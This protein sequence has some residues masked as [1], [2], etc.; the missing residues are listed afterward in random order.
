MRKVFGLMLLLCIGNLCIAQNK[1]IAVI[2]DADSK[3][4]LTGATTQ[5]IGTNI[6]T[7]SDKNGVVVITNIP[8][9]T[10]KASFSFT[11]YKEHTETLNFPRTEDTL[12]V[13]LEAAE[14]EMKNITISSTRSTRTIGNIPTRVEFIGGEELGEKGI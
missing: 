13:L 11:G 3:E 7:Q 10:H 1:M 6:A 12:L 2:K 8:N 9:G 14:G 5:L 4:P